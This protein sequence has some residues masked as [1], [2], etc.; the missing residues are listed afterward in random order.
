MDFI[1]NIKIGITRNSSSKELYI[2]ELFRKIIVFLNRIDFY[3]R[4]IK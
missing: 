3:Y 4:F 1:I 2:L